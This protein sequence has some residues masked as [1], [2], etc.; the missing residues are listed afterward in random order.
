MAKPIKQAYPITIRKDGKDIAPG[1][2]VSLPEDEANRIAALFGVI[3][4]TAA[5]PAPAPAPAP[6][7]PIAPPDPADE[8]AAA[9][10]ALAEAEKALDDA[11]EDLDPGALELLVQAAE[12]AEAKVAALKGAGS[13]APSLSGKPLTGAPL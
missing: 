6:V 7:P 9:E 12:D 11:P 4:A 13:S 10:A 3:P 2:P 1:T 5:A 8:L